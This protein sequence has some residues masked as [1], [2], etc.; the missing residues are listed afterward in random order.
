MCL[1][2]LISW[3]LVVDPLQRYSAKEILQH[4]WIAAQDPPQ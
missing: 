4:P 1:Q 2:E 3:S